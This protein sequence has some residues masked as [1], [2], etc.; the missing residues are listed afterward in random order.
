MTQKSEVEDGVPEACS[1][2]LEHL[3]E[4]LIQVDARR[5]EIRSAITTIQRLRQSEGRKF[6]Q[7][8]IDDLGTIGKEP[9][10]DSPTS[11]D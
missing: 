9:P 7:E 8:L 3:T 11:P 1:L 10:S 4:E 5:M 2:L 6:V